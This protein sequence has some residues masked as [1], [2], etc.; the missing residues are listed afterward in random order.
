MTPKHSGGGFCPAHSSTL[1]LPAS[2]S[3]PCPPIMSVPPTPLPPVAPLLPPVPG[4]P[5]LAPVERSGR[6]VTLGLPPQ[7]MT[8]KTALHAAVI[9]TIRP[10]ASEDMRGGSEVARDEID[11]AINLTY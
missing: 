6:E 11:R 1:P 8:R 10:R 7:A 5:P 2:F 3:P 4:M 9:R